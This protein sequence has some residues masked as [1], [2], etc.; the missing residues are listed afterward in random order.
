MSTILLIHGIGQQVLGPDL[1]HAHWHPALQSGVRLAGGPE[2]PPQDLSCPFYGDLFRPSGRA[3][4]DPPYD[5]SDVVAPEEAQLLDLW[6]RAAAEQNDSP[7]PDGSTR[8][9]TPQ[10]VQRA[11]NALSHSRFFA[12]IAERSLIFDLKQVHLYLHNPEIRAAVQSRVAAQVTSE[13]RLVIGHSLGSVV[14]YEALCAHPEWNIQHL[15]TLGSP[16]GIA[17]LIFDKLQPPPQN[18]KGI[19]PPSLESWINI[20]DQGDVVA[21]VKNLQPSFGARLTDLRIHNGSKAHDASPYLTAKETG[22]A[23]AAALNRAA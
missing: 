8:L 2:I 13:T 12:G 14:A 22:A 3:A 20:A 15:I 10:L 23:V 17:N 1:L 4:G 5:A 16:L 6:W 7:T 19:W 21:L 18:G 9:R 11:L